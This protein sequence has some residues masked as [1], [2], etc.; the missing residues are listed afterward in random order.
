MLESWNSEEIFLDGDSY[1]ER[2]ISDI[3]NARTY[4]TI[5]MYMFNDDIFGK[6]ICEHLSRANQRGVKVEIIVDGIGS[7]NFYNHLNEFFIKTGIKIKIYNPL[8]FYH[9]YPKEIDIAQKISILIQRIWRLNRR[10]HRKIFTIDYQILYV[11]S[12]NITAEHTRYN[13][14][15][16]WKDMGVRV[17]G[18]HVKFAVLNFKK[19]WKY[20]D[21]FRFKR[22]SKNHF[23]LNWKVSPLR[24]NQTIFMRRFLYKD[25]IWRI[26]RARNKIWLMTPYFIPKRS[27]IKA[28]GKAALNGVD[29]RILISQ[30][31]D[32][33]LF[34]W[35]QY[36]YFTYLIK[37]GVSIYLYDK[38]ILH[39][40]NYI[41]DHFMT[42]GS[43]NLNHRSL[44][45]D[46]EVDMIIQNKNN[47][48]VI[49]SNFIS[50]LKNQK[51]ISLDSLKER[52]L[53]DKLLS[54]IFFLFRYWL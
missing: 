36:F 41:I 45:H 16:M 52:S 22:K 27:L 50:C 34:K 37:S 4:I 47:K 15:N 6:K 32:V 43:S 9:P 38:S 48:A 25:L 33:K 19:N 40:K 1:F 20:K 10:D 54:K 21:Y 2:L 39:A 30:D 31:T 8:P 42:V 35:L 49:E 26:N 18:N 29:V 12:F 53:L 5:E 7:F 14:E 44:I 46:L 11:G 3:D 17:S 51:K 13:K 24:L 28:L 23:N